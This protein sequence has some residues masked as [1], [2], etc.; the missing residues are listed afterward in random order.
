MA[1]NRIFQTVDVLELVVTHPTTPESN[2]P[3][4]CGT[5]LIGVAETDERA[6]GKTTVR[7]DGVYRLSVIGHNGT[8]NTAVAIYD[9]LYYNDSRAPVLDVN[10]AGTL[11]GIALEAVASGATATIRV[12]L[13]QPA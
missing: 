12:A 4:R 1:T 10:S 6:D 9:K 2:Q 11:F 8:A 3:V 5:T 7:T 13:K